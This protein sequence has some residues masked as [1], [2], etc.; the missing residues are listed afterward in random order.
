MEDCFLEQLVLPEG[1]SFSSRE[2]IEA[3]QACV[4]L[5]VGGFPPRHLSA[6]FDGRAVI[7]A[8][9]IGPGKPQQEGHVRFAKFPATIFGP[10]LVEVLWQQLPG[11]QLDRR[12][13]GCGIPSAPGNCCRLLKRL[14]VDPEVALRAK[15]ERTGF[16]SQVPRARA[17]IGCED[18]TSSVKSLPEVIGS[19][20]SAEFRPEE[21]HGL[22]PVEAVTGSKGQ[23][24]Y[25]GGHLSQAPGIWGD[26][27][28]T[29]ANPKPTE[30]PHPYDGPARLTHR[31]LGPAHTLKA[32]RT[33]PLPLSG[34]TL[35]YALLAI[36]L[37]DR[38]IRQFENVEKLRAPLYV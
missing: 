17:P 9:L 2:G 23:Q 38:S 4:R 16:R 10:H 21:V 13:V 31:H 29:Y 11:V 5:F 1:I 32:R 26:D 22:L 18:P 12:P 35:P 7:F 6:C 25:Q 15:H 8:F 27:S 19:C 33:H 24:L 14:H 37:Q 30:Q 34:V 28:G 3:H 20:P 36:F